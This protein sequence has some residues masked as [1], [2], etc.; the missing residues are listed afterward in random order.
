MK[1]KSGHGKR[2][3][4]LLEPLL[5]LRSYPGGAGDGLPPPPDIPPDSASQHSPKYICL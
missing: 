1:F 5:D 4:H 3:C 2:P